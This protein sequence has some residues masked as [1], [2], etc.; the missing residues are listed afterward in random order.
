[1]RFK[2]HNSQEKDWCQMGVMKEGGPSWRRACCLNHLRPVNYPQNQ[3]MNKNRVFPCRHYV[4]QDQYKG[5][6]L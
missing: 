4:A 2:T 5:L 6:K 3:A 1:M